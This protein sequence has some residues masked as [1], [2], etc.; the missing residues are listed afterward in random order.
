MGL[1]KCFFLIE[2]EFVIIYFFSLIFKKIVLK[3]KHVIK[4]YKVHGSV[5][6]FGWLTWF[7][8]LESLTLFFDLN[9]SLLSFIF[10]LV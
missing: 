7:A 5:H 8:G 10:F 3:K 9:L 4:L 1:A 2:L 6:R